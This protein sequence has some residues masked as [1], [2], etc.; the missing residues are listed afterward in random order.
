MMLM[1]VKR[2][3][4]NQ[5]I[6]IMIGQGRVEIGHEDDDVSIRVYDP[7]GTAVGVS[8]LVRIKHFR[9]IK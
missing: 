1:R 4:H 6:V 3:L 5:K 8:G 9:G 2:L 7:D